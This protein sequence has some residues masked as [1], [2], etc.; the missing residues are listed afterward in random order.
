MKLLYRCRYCNKELSSLRNLKIHENK[1][2]RKLSHSC[3]YCNEKFSSKQKLYTHKHLI[4]QIKNGQQPKYNLTCKFCGLSKYVTKSTMINHEKHCD[5]NPNKIPY[6]KYVMSEQG[7]KNISI[8]MH[9]AALEGRNRGWTTTKSG[10]QNKS[11]PEEFFTKVIENEFND[12]NYIY[13]LPFYTW[14]LDFAWPNKKLC[15][16]IDGSQHEKIIEQK[17]SDLRKDTK[18]NEEGWKVL[19]IKWIDLYHK[20]Q[21]YIKQAKEFIDNGI[22]ITCEPY[23][24]PSKLKNKKES[25]IISEKIWIER[26]EKI[27]NCGVDLMKFGWVEKVIKNTGYSKSV[28]S[29]TIKHFEEE[30]KNKC[31]K[32]NKRCQQQSFLNYI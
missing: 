7:R 21:D 16:E 10:P 9:K 2:C 14:K 25:R 30:F 8:G 11:Y 20:T 19:R 12:K 6:K 27:L 31:F 32:R 5:K 18:L 22:I 29:Y 23:I 3:E 1:T 17:Q 26:K 4:H 15:I 28:I 13:N 24:N